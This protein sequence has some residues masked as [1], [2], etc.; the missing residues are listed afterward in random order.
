MT[1]DQVQIAA[2]AIASLADITGEQAPD[3][4]EALEESLILT[5]TQGEEILNVL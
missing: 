4:I 1:K 3:I 2:N 5:P